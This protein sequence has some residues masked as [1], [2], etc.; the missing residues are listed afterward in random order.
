MS[1]QWAPA[2]TPRG[3]RRWPR[4]LAWTGGVLFVF[5]VILYFFV[6]S[7]TFLEAFVLPKVSASLGAPVTISDS[8]ISPFRKVILRDLKVGGGSFE[9]PII[10]VRE[11][12]ARYSLWDIIG[13]NINI[14]EVAIIS[15]VIQIVQLEDG[16]SN[17]DPLLNKPESPP[18]SNEASQP[19]QLELGRFILTNATVRYTRH[20]PDGGRE[21]AE[22]SDINISVANLRNAQVAALNFGV[23]IRFER[24]PAQNAT[25]ATGERIVANLSGQFEL[26]LTADLK[27]ESLRG[28][29]TLDLL[30]PPAA[31]R[32]IKGTVAVLDCDLTPTDLRQL[33]LTFKQG[34]N[35]L[36]AITAKGPLDLQRKE[37]QINLEIAS[38]GRHALNLFGAA[39]G[40]DFG[41][42]TLNATQQ[43]SIANSGRRIVATGRLAADK[44]SVVQ[45]SAATRPLD[46]TLDYDVTLDQEH[47]FALIQR[48]SLAGTQ[49]SIPILRGDLSSPMRLDLSGGTNSLGPS[50]FNLQLTNFNLADW[51]AFVGD[52][53]GIASAGLN[54]TAADAGKQLA[55]HLDSRVTDLNATLGSNKLH[56]ADLSVAL[57]AAFD[58]RKTFRLDDF[59]V[60]LGRGSQSALTLSASARGD[61]AQQLA[62]MTL[63]IDADLPR[64][65]DLIA[66]AGLPSVT[67]KL[68]SQI[69]QRGK[70]F[71]ITNFVTEFRQAGRAAAVLNLTGFYD[72]GLTN[73]GAVLRLQASDLLALAPTNPAPGK[74]LSLDLTVDTSL[75]KNVATVRDLAGRLAQSGKPGGSFAVTAKFNL[76]DQTGDLTLNVTDL[77]EATLGAFLDPALGNGRSL[78]SCSL[79]LKADARYDP[80]AATSLNADLDLTR[81]VLADPAKQSPE[82]L[83]TRA[84]FAGSMQND[85][86]VLNNFSADLAVG[87]AASGQVRASGKYH[88]KTKAAE[89]TLRVIDL[90]QRLLAPLM[91][92]ALT[93]KQ[94][95][96]VSVNVDLGG[97][98]DPAR[99]ASIKGEINLNNLLVS[100]AQGK[101]P[102]TPLS[103]GL[104]LNTA[105]AANKLVNIETCRLKLAPTPRARN[106]LSLSGTLDLARTNI[107]GGNLQLSA[108]SLDVTPYYDQFTTT[109]PTNAAPARTAASS[110]PPASSSPGAAPREPDPVNLPFDKFNL[111]INIGQL[112]LREVAVQNWQTTVA[113]GGSRVQVS[114]LQLSLNGAPVKGALAMNLGVPGYQYD[115]SFSAAKVP[116]AP[117]VDSFAPEQKGKVK[118]DLILASQIKGAGVT[119]RSLQKS[120]AG[121]FS[122]SLTNANLK[123]T[124]GGAKGLLPIVKGFFTTVGLFIGVPDLAGS[125]IS[126]L[127]GEARVNNGTINVAQLNVVSEA[128]TADTQGDIK[129]AEVLATSPLEKLPMHLWLRRS[130]AQRLGKIPR[131]TPPDANYVKMPDFVRVAGTISAPKPELNRMAL[132]GA[133]ADKFLDSALKDTTGGLNP[134][135]PLGK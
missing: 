62:D 85:E 111:A 58:D 59:L 86:I 118:G 23:G 37:G 13:G 41:S 105:I 106:E 127:A 79:K 94:L 88:L 24:I 130:L 117:F 1:D 57:R 74:P 112:Y 66:V 38:I 133:I 103:V 47:K 42:T 43:I 3:P 46:L 97:R 8:G 40:L 110:S 18:D 14:H 101:L 49:N 50:A 113:I 69:L 121:D 76:L 93:N 135:N 122:V 52:I 98:Y 125:P 67:V 124:D 22:L 48:F 107:I 26:G 31:A 30:T 129:I 100:D 83:N 109:S 35:T 91:A 77:N 21:V 5:L 95:V 61:V 53:S 27:P 84:K 116:V 63:K 78:K 55:V 16:T 15:P 99:D 82:S 7:Q 119:G 64:V 44:L 108:D 12:R 120:L 2:P 114:P 34:A 96:S 32:D 65:T 115:L 102:Q 36:G 89:G 19:P 54:V 134:L 51:R 33:T 75:D 87:E 39:S 56:R 70:R 9:E 68:N 20:F 92:A 6:T 128:F 10:T 45:N 4:R 71:Q 72:L 25:N 81:L 132:A 90:N 123:L 73:G 104:E 60:R 11:V 17:L 131:N 126:W 80:K 29:T 28:S